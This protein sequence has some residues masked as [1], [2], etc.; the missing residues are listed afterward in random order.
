M[1]NFR[2]IHIG[3]FI[4]NVVQVKE[5][6][7]GRILN[8][9]KCQEDQI[10][11]MYN[12]SSLDSDL[13]LRWSKL[14]EYDLFRLYSQHLMLYSPVITNKTNK[15]TNDNS[16][17]KFRKNIYTKEVIDFILDQIK[18]EKMSKREIIE[19]YNIPKTTLYK[20]IIKYN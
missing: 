12:K 19:R 5:I 11:E 13:L 6:D 7:T 18:N 1:K 2:E 16:L 4:K 15:K 20:W 9:F 8:F 3:S 14:L 10:E 17:P